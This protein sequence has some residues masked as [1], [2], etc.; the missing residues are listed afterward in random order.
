VILLRIFQKEHFVSCWKSTASETSTEKLAMNETESKAGSLVI[1]CPTNE[2]VWKH[3]HQVEK[4][5]FAMTAIIVNRL[6][7]AVTIVMNVLVIM[8]V[9]TRPRLQNKYVIK[10]LSLSEYCRYHKATHLML[11]IPIFASLLHLTL[12]SI[13]RFVAMKYTFRYMTIVTGLRLKTAVVSSWVIACCPAVLEN[14]SEEFEIITNIAISLF[15]FFNFSLILFC[16]LSIGSLCNPSSRETNQM[17]TSFTT[18][19]CRLPKGE[20]SSGNHQ[21]NWNGFECMSLP[22]VYAYFVFERLF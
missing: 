12:I 8:T 7:F 11:F 2:M 16:R 21:D 14:L 4:I 13:E 19:C 6:S 20:E 17:W 9:K 15:T 22:P 3:E 1:L 10:V 18:S 5:A